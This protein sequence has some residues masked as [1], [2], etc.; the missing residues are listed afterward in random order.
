MVNPEKRQTILC[1]HESGQSNRQISKLLKISRNTVRKIL[2]NQAESTKAQDIPNQEVI[3]II[4]KLFTRCEGNVVR[5]QEILLDEYQ[6]NLPYSTLTHIVRELQLRQPKRRSG[7]YPTE[8]GKEMQHDTSPHHVIIK[9]KKIKAQCAALVFAYSR[10][11]YVQYYPCFTRFEAKA[12]LQSGIEFM[13]GSCSQCVIDNTSVILASGSGADAV[14]APETETFGRIYGFKFIAH[15]VGHAD[16]KAHVERA[17]HYVENNFLSGRSFDSW[18]DLNQQARLWCENTANQKEK[19]SLGMSPEVAYIQEKPYLTSLPKVSPPVYAHYHRIVDSQGFINLDTNRYSVPEKF[20]GKTLDVY[21]HI[22]YV[23][24]YHKNNKVAEHNRC[25]DKRYARV[26]IESHH[27]TLYQHKASQAIIEA[28]QAL[29]GKFNVLDEYLT[30]LKQHVKGRGLRQLNRLVHFKR[31][32]PSQA[33]MKAI[34]QAH[35]YKLYD[36]NRLEDLIIK[37][38][39]GD[40]FNINLGETNE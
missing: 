6:Q 5:I 23:R 32:Y 28:E 15:A 38:V 10:K 12:F 11:L 21:K 7:H 9:G 4:R 13:Q 31:T 17:F 39:A 34:E 27:P 24:I 40:F 37:C 8:P 25:I 16:R 26:I 1:L 18:D 36:L 2:E 33:F 29:K 3:P 20:I 19:R 30:V 35:T 14:M 22:V